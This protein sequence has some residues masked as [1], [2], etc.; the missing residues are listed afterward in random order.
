MPAVARS[1]YVAECFWPGVGKRDL[2]ALDER[3]ATA[4]GLLASK[5][6]TVRYL[7]SLLFQEDE[8]V[9]C[10]FAGEEAAIREV[11][12]AARI[13]FARIVASARS[14]RALAANGAQDAR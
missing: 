1:E 10:M 11:A 5:G 7:G 3:A 13:P 14:P 6:R 4:A 9:L 2:N 8:V 12:A